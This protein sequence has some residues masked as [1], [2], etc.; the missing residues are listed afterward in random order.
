[1]VASNVAVL[2][3]DGTAANDVVAEEPAT[4]AISGTGLVAV[5]PVVAGAPVAAFAAF[6]ARLAGGQHGD[7]CE[8]ADANNDLHG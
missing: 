6:L 8:K 7:N 5:G 1:V 3:A 2:A 4:I